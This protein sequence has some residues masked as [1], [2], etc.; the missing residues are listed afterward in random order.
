MPSPDDAPL[1]HDDDDDDDGFKDLFI[2]FQQCHH[3]HSNPVAIIFFRYRFP[4]FMLHGCSKNNFYFYCAPIPEPV[5][6]A[7]DGYFFSPFMC[8]IFILLLVFVAGFFFG[9]HFRKRPPKCY[10][11]ERLPVPPL[12]AHRN[13]C[14]VYLERAKKN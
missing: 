10:A 13:N 6:E 12:P 11:L 1:I 3:N 14:S 8:T 4:I 5:D 9:N 7:S 2:C